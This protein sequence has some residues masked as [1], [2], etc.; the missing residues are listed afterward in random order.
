MNSIAH[1]DAHDDIAYYQGVLDDL[2]EALAK[3]SDPSDWSDGDKLRMLAA[4]FD[5]ADM[6]RGV[7]DQH[8]VQEDLRRMADKL[9]E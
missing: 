3:N 4:F 6:A 8:E 5:E 2:K 9:D 7:T 1:D